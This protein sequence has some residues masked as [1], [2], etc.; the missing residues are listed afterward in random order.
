ME[1]N[2]EKNMT[3]YERKLQARESAA[4]R[5]KRKNLLSVVVTVAIIGCIAALLIVVP[6]LKKKEIFKEYFKVNEESVSELEFYFHKTN[7]I[8]NNYEIL[9]YMGI[10]SV[11]DLSTQYYNEEEGIT[12][13]DFFTESA[14][15]SIKENKALIADAKAKNISLDV[16]T[17][18]D[19]YLA[20]FKTDADSMGISL[21]SYLTSYYGASEKDLRQIMKD[22]IAALLYS[23]YLSEQNG[24]TD[25]EVQAKYEEQKANYDSIDYRVLPIPAAVNADSTEEEIATA[26]EAAKAKAQEML[27]KVNAG[28]DF[29]TLCATYAQEDQR[30][31]YADSETDLS[32]VKGASATNSSATYL[33]W[34]YEIDHNVGDA[35][36]FTDDLG[37]AQYVLLYVDRYVADGVMDSIK[38]DL[39]Y[40]NVMAYIEEISASYVISDPEDNIPN[41]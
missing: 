32:L 33:S 13:D 9:Q 34:F 8:N 28:E 22:N 17:E 5:E 25:E 1:Q 6:M 2:N 36:I 18:Y 31:N 21:D 19:A 4:K 20:N 10:S 7:L 24:A 14:A 27:D 40:E 16:D 35:G 11:A 37:H 29:E 12:W 41:L 39:T 15:N 30:A 23:N 3:S 26:M 38:E